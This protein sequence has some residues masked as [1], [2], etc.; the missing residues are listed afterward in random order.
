MGYKEPVVI[1]VVTLLISPITKSHDPL[2]N[3][4][5][6]KALVPLEGTCALNTN[7]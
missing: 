5:R 2:S 1:T 3:H 7:P 4:A 6:G